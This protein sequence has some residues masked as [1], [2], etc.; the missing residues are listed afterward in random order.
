M[1]ATVPASASTTAITTTCTCACHALTNRQAARVVYVLGCLVASRRLFPSHGHLAPALWKMTTDANLDATIDCHCTTELALAATSAHPALQSINFRLSLNTV[2]FAADE[3]RL[4]S[5]GPLPFDVTPPFDN[6]HDPLLL[7]VR[8]MWWR[9]PSAFAAD[10][11]SPVSLPEVL[12]SMRR[13]LGYTRRM[14]MLGKAGHDVYRIV[15]PLLVDVLHAQTCPNNTAV[16]AA[17]TMH[18][19]SAAVSHMVSVCPCSVVSGPLHDHVRVS[20]RYV[21]ACQCAFFSRIIVCSPP[22]VAW[23]ILM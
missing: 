1:A 7:S 16:L 14:I 4:S 2:A 6:R 9:A 5:G 12:A 11:T 19:H 13:A 15:L 3:A 23:S 18:A 8:D 20:R 10:I 21:A 17:K 22:S